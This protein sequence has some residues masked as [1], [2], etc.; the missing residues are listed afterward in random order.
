[1]GTCVKFSKKKN[2]NSIC[3]EQCCQKITMLP[4]NAIGAFRG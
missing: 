3:N 2:K 1:L 4:K